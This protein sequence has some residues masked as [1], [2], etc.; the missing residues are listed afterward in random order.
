VENIGNV[1]NR[2]FELEL[3]HAKT[4]GDFSYTVGVNYTFARNRIL[5]IDEPSNIAESRRRTGK[6]MGQWFGFIADGFYQSEEDVNKSPKFHDV[7]P[8]PGEIKYRDLNGDGI[9]D[10]NDITAIGRSSTPENILGV[11]LGARFR[12]FD[13]SCLFQGASGFSIMPR[14]EGVFEFLDGG[15]AT[16]I[17]LDNWTPDNPKAAYPR[18]SLDR[19]SYKQENSTFWLKDASYIRLRSAEIGY[20]L[21][22]KIFPANSISQLRLYVSGTNLLTFSKF[23]WYD[24]EAPSGNSIWYPVMKTVNIGANLSF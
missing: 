4:I 14:G 24:P 15:S 18:L 23:N 19:Y 10:D 2:G 5:F 8:R 17:I 22:K 21:P 12:G 9:I 7:D 11:N 20:T 1:L 6:A 16:K 13:F 3:N